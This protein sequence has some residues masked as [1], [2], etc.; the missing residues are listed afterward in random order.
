MIDTRERIGNGTAETCTGL[1]FFIG[2]QENNP[3]HAYRGYNPIIII[4]LSGADTWNI[5]G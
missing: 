3:F 4:S 2:W 1:L 5:G